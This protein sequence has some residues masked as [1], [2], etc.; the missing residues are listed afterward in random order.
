MDRESS[1]ASKVSAS[2][3]AQRIAVEDFTQAAFEGV[4]RAIEA[5][6]VEERQRLP[7]GP[8]IYGIIWDPDFQPDEVFGPRSDTPER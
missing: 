8:I 2:T 3:S 5:R 4:L 1:E 7:F 6:N